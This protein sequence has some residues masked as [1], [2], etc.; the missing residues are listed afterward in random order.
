MP[1]F[2]W[3]E[4]FV[5]MQSNLKVNRTFVCPCRIKGTALVLVYIMR[6]RCNKPHFDCLV[7]DIVD[8]KAYVQHQSDKWEANYECDPELQDYSLDDM[9]R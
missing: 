1:V 2:Y 8:K 7:Y 5:A 3:W 6:T 4:L 9:N